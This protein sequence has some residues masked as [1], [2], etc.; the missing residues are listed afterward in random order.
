MADFTLPNTEEGELFRKKS[1]REGVF[2]LLHQRI[3]AGKYSPGEWL[4]QEEI[5]SQLGVSQTPVREALDL[6]VSVGLAERVPYRGVR[7]PE[8]SAEEI[9][10]A[11]IL[12]LLLESAAARMAALNITPERSEILRQIVEKTRGLITLED[13][14]QQRQLNRR[15]HSYIA[16]LSENFLLI[17]IYQMTSNLFPDWRLYEYMFR[18]PELLEKDLR[19]EYS[20]HEAICE[21]IVARQPDKAA[22]CAVI[23]IRNLRSELV[24]Y[25]G[26][27]EALLAEK[28]DQIAPL[29]SVGA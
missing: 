24:N 7:V 20:E 6:L 25:L 11:Y 23:H 1:L 26:I 10:D 2:E 3:V 15:F 14:S 21:A 22:R 12:R 17:K 27:S 18:H 29:L 8:W 28:E 16:E 9:V 4:R 19:R 5:S 13:M